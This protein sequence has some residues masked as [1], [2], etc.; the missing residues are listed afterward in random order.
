MNTEQTPVDADASAPTSAVTIDPELQE[1]VTGARK[2]IELLAERLRERLGWPD[3]DWD[4]T[5]T[6]CVEGVRVEASIGDTMSVTVTIGPSLVGLRIVG[7][8]RGF[9]WDNLAFPVKLET[10][11]RLPRSGFSS[12][13][14]LRVVERV[15]PES[16]WP[17]RDDTGNAA[18]SPDGQE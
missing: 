2:G 13:L 5:V 4:E 6:I 12:D 16:I 1:R 15:T 7:D 14:F 18:E 3:I 8:A 10:S 11:Y 9:D 17:G